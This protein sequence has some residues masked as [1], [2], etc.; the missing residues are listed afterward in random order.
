[1]W[2]V[3]LCKSKCMCGKGKLSEEGIF[4]KQGA[5]GRSVTSSPYQRMT[6]D[7][8]RENH[9]ARVKSV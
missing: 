4:I 5:D 7:G 8:Q 1:M 3:I 9:D 2:W 6:S